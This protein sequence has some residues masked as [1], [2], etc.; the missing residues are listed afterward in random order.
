MKSLTLLNIRC[1]ASFPSSQPATSTIDKTQRMDLIPE[2]FPG[3]RLNYA[4]NLLRYQ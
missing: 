3:S 2:W 4:E 1:A